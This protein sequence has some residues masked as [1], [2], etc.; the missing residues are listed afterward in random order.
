[1]TKNN[2][3]PFNDKKTNKKGQQKQD[4]QLALAIEMAHAEKRTQSGIEPGVEGAD[5]AVD[6]LLSI[7]DELKLIKNTADTNLS[8]GGKPLNESNQ[9]QLDNLNEDNNSEANTSTEK[10]SSHSTEKKVFLPNFSKI[11]FF[12][13][14]LKF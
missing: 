14:K 2:I 12:L 13:L 8:R 11:I 4:K 5:E 1:M 10:K 3:R 7:E 9:S 6:S